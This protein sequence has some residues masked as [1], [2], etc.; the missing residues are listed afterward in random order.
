MEMEDRIIDLET[1]ITYQDDLLQKLD[2][3]VATQQKEIDELK[4]QV[5]HI[6]QQLQVVHQSA[7]Q[8]EEPPPPHY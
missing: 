1:R 7:T 2:E 4:L 3:V 8:S 6:S 5:R